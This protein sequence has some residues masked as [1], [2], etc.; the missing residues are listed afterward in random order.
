MGQS[1]AVVHNFHE[2][3]RYS[4]TT[5]DEPFWEAVYRKAFP[6]LVCQV[7]CKGNNEAQHKG[8]DRVLMLANG[9]IVKIDEK[10]RERDYSDILLETVS[11]DRTG[12]VGWIEKD[13][14]ID[15]LA[16]AFMPS[17]RCY[18]LDWQMLRRAW[19]ANKAAW[20]EQFKK[21]EAKNAGYSTWS[22]AVPIKTVLVAMATA[23]MIEVG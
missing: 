14:D 15:Y 16:Y 7:I 11:N 21:I 9:R 12:A 19:Q 3:L 23:S 2:R 6:S 8:I 13:L 18:M 10:K 4:Q 22:L 20:I 17:K 1:V 5:S